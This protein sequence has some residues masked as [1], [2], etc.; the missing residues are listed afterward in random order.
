MSPRRLVAAAIV[1]LALAAVLAAP[2]AAD[3]AVTTDR[4]GVET[5]LGRDFHFRTTVTNDGATATEPLVAH[6]N[7]L[8]LT[9]SVYVDPED[10]STQRT[11]YLGSIPAGG[12]R[13]ITWNIKAVNDGDFAAYATILS[14]NDP[15]GP[16]P[17]TDD[18]QLRR[19]RPARARDPGRAGGARRRRPALQAAGDFARPLRRSGPRARPEGARRRRPRRQRACRRRRPRTTP[20][21]TAAAM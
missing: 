15:A 7:I 3:V 12:E 8:S 9:S 16:A 2:A 17:A 21:A 14:Q 20:A 19:D 5:Q 11:Q 10:W 6:L 1:A 4:A 13:T 18:A